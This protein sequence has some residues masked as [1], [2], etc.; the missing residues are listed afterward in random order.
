MKWVI[1]MQL[2]GEG[3]VSG[4]YL[5]LGWA[6]DNFKPV[7]YRKRLDRLPLWWS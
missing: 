7:L 6:W 5:S 1:Y 2:H 3:E 4:Y